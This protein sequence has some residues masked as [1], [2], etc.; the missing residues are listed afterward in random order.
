MYKRTVSLLLSVFLFCSFTTSSWAFY[1]IN[2][3]SDWINAYHKLTQEM[4]EFYEEKALILDQEQ[5]VFKYKALIKDMVAKGEFLS[6]K[7]FDLRITSSDLKKWSDRIY[8]LNQ[9][10][11]IKAKNLEGVTSEEVVSQIELLIDNH[12]Y[13]SWWD[14]VVSFFSSGALW[15]AALTVLGAIAGALYFVFQNKKTQ[16]DTS[17]ASWEVKQQP[18]GDFKIHCGD[19]TTEIHKK[20]YGYNVCQAYPR[21]YTVRPTIIYDATYDKMDSYYSRY[22]YSMNSTCILPAN[23][24]LRMQNFPLNIKLVERMFEELDQIR[25][26]FF[27]FPRNVI[28]DHCQFNI[29]VIPLTSLPNIV[30][31]SPTGTILH[32]KGYKGKKF[33]RYPQLDKSP[34]KRYPPFF[35]YPKYSTTS[36][37]G[38]F[39]FASYPQKTF[40]DP[41][42]NFGFGSYPQPSYSSYPGGY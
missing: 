37:Y 26:L 14:S 30:I 27:T 1:K 41:F 20:Y 22:S 15:G 17:L 13:T 10:L 28:N 39:D 23:T 19:G 18:S 40:P 35:P 7:L 4:V 34:F 16:E 38:K 29:G 32:P 12:V 11:K 21:L 31:I 6:G 5:I 2:T 9:D 3:L 25:S 42:G 36:G 33:G 24:V 8:H